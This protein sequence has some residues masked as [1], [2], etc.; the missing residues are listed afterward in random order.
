[1]KKAWETWDDSIFIFIYLDSRDSKSFGSRH[2]W[3][4]ILMQSICT[5]ASGLSESQTVTTSCERDSRAKTQGRK[6]EPGIKAKLLGLREEAGLREGARD[7]RGLG[8]K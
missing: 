6:V 2:L 4:K 7:L 8:L 5:P 1:M 3:M